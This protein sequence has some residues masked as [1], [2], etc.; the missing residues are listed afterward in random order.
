MGRGRRS[1]P[2]RRVI[3]GQGMTHSLYKARPHTSTMAS[4]LGGFAVGQTRRTDPSTP[5]VRR[6]SSCGRMAFINFHMIRH[7]VQAGSYNGVQAGGGRRWNPSTPR[8]PT[9]KG[10]LQRPEANRSTGPGRCSCRSRLLVLPS[11]GAEDGC[12]G[13]QRLRR[14]SS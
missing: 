6:W 7:G 4:Q 12:S 5:L 11:C 2:S 3:E 1:S 13:R 14:P 9:I 8:Y 10:P